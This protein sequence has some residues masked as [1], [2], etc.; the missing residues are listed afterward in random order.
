MNFWSLEFNLSLCIS[1]LC[2]SRY[3]VAL[4]RGSQK[5]GNNQGYGIL[6]Q[7]QLKQSSDWRTMQ[8]FGLHICHDASRN[9]AFLILLVE[10]EV[11]QPPV[12]LSLTA[13]FWPVTAVI[14]LL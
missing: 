12:S 1:M 10:S 8:V 13:V 7:K 2:D 6:K 3:V 11:L 4:F 14:Q 9:T 5:R